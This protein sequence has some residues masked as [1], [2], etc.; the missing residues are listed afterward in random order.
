MLG[1]VTIG[2]SP[3]EDIVQSMFVH[4]TV[5]RLLQL[6]ALD[7]LSPAEIAALSPQPGEHPLVTRLADG[8]EVVVAKERLTDVMNAAIERVERLGAS[9]VCVLCT[10]EFAGLE[11]RQRIVYPDRVL[12]GVVDAML[13]DGKLGVIMPH[14]GQRQSMVRKWGRPAR[15]VELRVA[16]PY[17]ASGSFECAASELTSMG[18][19]MV[20]LDCMGYSKTMQAQAQS[21]IKIPVLLA[22]GV[23]GAVLAAAVPGLSSLAQDAAAV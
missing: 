8:T 3:R 18:C 10:G 5:P 23:V 16:S 1:L 14:E 9:I 22:N 15:S 17:Q 4:G 21:A 12:A 2:Q 6:G 19:E 13:P 20:V 7:G 11:S